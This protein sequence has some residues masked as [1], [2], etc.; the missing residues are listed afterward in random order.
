MSKKPKL[1]H[2]WFFPGNKHAWLLICCNFLHYLVKTAITYLSHV[3]PPSTDAPQSVHFLGAEQA[4]CVP[5]R[6]HVL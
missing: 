2:K 3:P 1:E 6:V 5:V 4:V